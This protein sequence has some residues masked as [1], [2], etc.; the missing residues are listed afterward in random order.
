M[1]FVAVGT[2]GRVEP[3]EMLGGIG[4]AGFTS[5]AIFALLASS[6][7][8]SNW[9]LIA[10]SS[11]VSSWDLVGERPGL[12]SCRSC[13]CRSYIVRGFMFY[14][15]TM[16]MSSIGRRVACVRLGAWIANRFVP[17][18]GGSLTRTWRPKNKFPYQLRPT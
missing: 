12:G 10:S 6:R 17:L 13:F 14:V 3:S 15:G 9:G 8:V 1:S 5:L 18:L 11:P 2:V 16:T 4:C 7:R